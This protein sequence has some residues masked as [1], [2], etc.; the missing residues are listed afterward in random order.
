MLKKSKKVKETTTQRHC[1]RRGRREEK[2][3]DVIRP[4]G[5][6]RKKKG[7]I[8]SLTWT[9]SP[10][11]HQG[12]TKEKNVRGFVQEKHRKAYRGEG[13]NEGIV[14]IVVRPPVWCGGKVEKGGK[15]GHGTQREG[16][17]YGHT[18]TRKRRDDGSNR[19]LKPDVFWAHTE[20][21]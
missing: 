16:Q 17:K 18:K 8:S 3:S 12:N 20:E 10:Q 2:V 11:P 14:S 4:Q 19:G 9:K 5:K 21:S 1:P 13:K 15:R 6:A 7:N